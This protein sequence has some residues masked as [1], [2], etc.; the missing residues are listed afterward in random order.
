MGRQF[1]RGKIMKKNN[2]A[3]SERINGAALHLIQTY[4][5]KGW[6]MDMLCEEAG[7]A[8]DTLYRFIEN[9]DS[10]IK[11][12]IE[13]V[14]EKY[15]NDILTILS[16]EKD[17]FKILSLLAQRL[18]I[19]LKELGTAQIRSLFKEYPYIEKSIRQ[20]GDSLDKNISTYLK[21]GIEEGLIKSNINTLLVA[22][23]VKH[24]IIAIINDESIEN[25]NSAIDSFLKYIIY[26][27]GK[28]AD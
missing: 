28:T 4:G 21:K 5:V 26:G 24:S 8:K 17:F 11:S 25:S 16:L 12:V 7:L 20:F 6:T 13:D 23:I 1:L 10:L 27:I 14:L 19:I 2:T 22:K 9:K 3:L 18:T 15:K